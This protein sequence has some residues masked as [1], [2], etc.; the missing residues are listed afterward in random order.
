M[1]EQTVALLALAD[2][3]IPGGRQELLKDLRPLLNAD[4]FYTPHQIAEM[5]GMSLS[6]VRNWSTTGKLVPSI[7]VDNGTVR[8]T[9]EDIDRFVDNNRNNNT[10][11]DPE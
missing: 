10:K 4:R 6:T 5:F 9:Q 3:I 1:R 2:A 8:Y 11:T 7:K